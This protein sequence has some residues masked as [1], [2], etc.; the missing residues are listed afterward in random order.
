MSDAVQH[1][2]E[3][4]DRNAQRIT[5]L[6]GRKL[7]D[8]PQGEGKRL[9]GRRPVEAGENLPLHLLMMK[10]DIHRQ[11]WRAPAACRI[12]PALERLIDLIHLPVSLTGPACL[13]DL[14]VQDAEQPG[15][16]A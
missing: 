11:R 5:D 8:F 6:F 3:V 9:A 7:L 1:H 13:G 12:E 2:T 16:H 4:S 14:V 10:G 15:S